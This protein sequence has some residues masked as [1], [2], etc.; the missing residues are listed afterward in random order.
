MEFEARN[1]DKLEVL[2]LLSPS[3]SLV[4]PVTCH[5]LCQSPIYCLSS[6]SIL[7]LLW[8]NEAGSCKCLSFA[9]WHMLTLLGEGAGGALLEGK[10]FL[11]LVQAPD[12]HALSAPDC[13]ANG[14][15]E[16]S[17]QGLVTSSLP[18]R[19][20]GSFAVSSASMGPQQLHGH[21]VSR[22]CALQDVRIAALGWRLL[23]I[24]ANFI[25]FRALFSPH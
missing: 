21:L 7:Q 16:P 22:D 17:S 13:C 8:V 20:L 25:V 5:G 10:G 12:V 11:F 15:L 3:R 24:S 19:L 23:F 2:C 1:V 6:A 14:P 18:Q 9:S 4:V